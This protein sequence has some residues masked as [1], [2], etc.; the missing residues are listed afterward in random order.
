MI[1]QMKKLTFL[2]YHKEYKQFLVS[3]QNLGVVHV[4]KNSNIS[5]ASSLV[6]SNVITE[7]EEQIKSV[8]NVIDALSKIEG[9]KPIDAEKGIADIALQYVVQYDGL[10]DEMRVNVADIQRYNRD[11]AVLSPWGVYDHSLV[12]KLEDKGIKLSYYQAPVSFFK[13]HPEYA[14]GEVSRVGKIAY[15]VN[16]AEADAEDEVPATPITLPEETYEECVNKLSLLH[17]QEQLLHE[18]KQSLAINHLNDIAAYELLLQNELATLRAQEATALVADNKVMVLEGWF[19]VDKQSEIEA[20]L[21][22]TESYYE[23]REPV[24]TDNVPIK[25]RNNRFNSMFECLTKMYGFP[26]YN[27]WDPTPLVAPFFTLFF[28]ICMGDAGYG[29]CILIYGLFEMAG[30][31]KKTPIIGEMVEGYGSMITTLGVATIIVGLALGTFF[32]VNVNNMSFLPECVH[33]YYALVQGNFP[34][35]TYSF[36]MISAIII[37]VFHLCIAMLVKAILFSVKE[38]FTSQIAQWGWCLLIIGSVVTGTLSLMGTFSQEVTTMI[39]IGVGGVSAVCIYLLN[40]VQRLQNKFIQ[41]LVINPL[42]GLYDTYNMASGLLGDVLSYI[43]LYALCLAGGM[44]GQAFNLIGDMCPIWAGIFIY[45]IGHLLN[46]L[47]S[48]ISAFVHP[49]RLNFVEYF[50]NAGYE[51]AGTEYK[52]FSKK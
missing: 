16:F 2:V 36:Q 49:L 10:V 26:S 23:M 20:F 15:F 14:E 4:Q 46:L 8:K 3:L 17:E 40:N 51:G 13:A 33:N 47:L 18:Q 52:P 11:L 5:E 37:G 35:T 39:L 28:A 30:K 25:F 6:S 48:A 43:R 50:K 42:A 7:K 12:K 38:G 27:E 9:V 44:L 19:P 1:Q 34:G 22:N 21:K 45:F 32:G 24:A 41:G 29:I 31:A